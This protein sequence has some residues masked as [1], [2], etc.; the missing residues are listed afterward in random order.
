MRGQL[1]ATALVVLL[2]CATHVRAEWVLLDDFSGQGPIGGTSWYQTTPI[3]NFQMGNGRLFALGKAMAVHRHFPE[4]GGQQHIRFEAYSGLPGVGTR[5]SSVQTIS[6][7]LGA[8]DSSNYYEVR[9]LAD[10]LLS[11]DFYRLHLYSVIGG[12][13]TNDLTLNF[14]TQ[15]DAV[16]LDAYLNGSNVTVSVQPVDRLTG[17][18]IGTPLNRSFASVPDV[19]GGNP[20][21]SRVGLGA[22]GRYV[23][24]DDFEG[25]VA[26][27]ATTFMAAV[28]AC[29]PLLRARRIRPTS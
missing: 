23:E 4:A 22:Q 7:I 18:D 26:P 2:W 3:E 16:R 15:L 21:L 17:L 24:I 8:K 25:F 6:A 28:L 20:D 13:A 14:D 10:N 12:V 29:L 5:D 9:L 19:L 1:T 27:E 11:T